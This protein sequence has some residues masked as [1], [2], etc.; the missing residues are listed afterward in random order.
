MCRGDQAARRPVRHRNLLPAS[1]QQGGDAQGL[2]VEFAP[3]P[4][5]LYR[6]ERG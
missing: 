6:V 5:S 2:G 1:A 4:Q 3:L